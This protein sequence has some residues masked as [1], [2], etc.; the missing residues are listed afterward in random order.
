MQIKFKL[1][2]KGKFV[3]HERHALREGLMRIDHSYDGKD[4]EL[5]LGQ[6]EWSI[7]HDEK[8]LFTGWTDKN[9]VDI[10]DGDDTNQG[11]IAWFSNLS[12]DGN[13]SIHP[14]FFFEGGFWR[15][16]CD[17]HEMDYH[18]G[19]G[20]DI[21]VL[22]VKK[23]CERIEAERHEVC[24]GPGKCVICYPET[25]PPCP[26]PVCKNNSEVINDNK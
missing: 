12:W 22:P 8:R 21:E 23:L 7:D 11:K 13:G 10:Y 18:T 26:C 9:G 19:F 16:D 24:K 3:G 17:E 5:V 4:W 14:G 6:D 2:L 25:M 15:N 1:Y 20:E